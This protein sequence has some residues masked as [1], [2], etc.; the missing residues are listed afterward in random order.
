MSSALTSFCQIQKGSTFL[1]YNTSLPNRSNYHQVGLSV[2]KFYSDN[3]SLVAGFNVGRVSPTYA[4]LKGN[5]SNSELSGVYN[6]LK[7]GSEIGLKYY[8][9][10]KIKNLYMHYALLFNTDMQHGTWSNTGLANQP[11]DY[12]QRVSLNLHLGATYLLNDRWAIDC[13]LLGIGYGKTFGA[14][15]NAAPHFPTIGGGTRSIYNGAINLPSPTIGI[16]YNFNRKK[17]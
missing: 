2:E 15:K 8:A 17:S 7:I 10:T 9:P 16:K 5:A 12:S 4:I 1:N 3:M 13:N 6:Y 14:D 11:K